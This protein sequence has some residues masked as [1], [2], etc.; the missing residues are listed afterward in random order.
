E[1][2]AEIK[3]EEARQGIMM[4]KTHRSSESK[5][6]ALA[7]RNLNEE[8]KSDEVPWCDYCKRKWHTRE[9]CWKLK[10]KPPNWK[11]RGGRAF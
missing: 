7:T 10:G 1:T 3:R 11:K 2:F 4:G 6:S 8:K 9:N 5:G